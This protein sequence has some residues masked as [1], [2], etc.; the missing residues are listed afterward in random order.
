MLPLK[1]GVGTPAQRHFAVYH[2]VV[3]QIFDGAPH[4]AT[5][6]PFIQALATQLGVDG[7]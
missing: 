6:Q 2:F 1:Q 5:M 7:E 3:H 4:E